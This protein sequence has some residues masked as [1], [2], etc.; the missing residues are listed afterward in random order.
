MNDD[1]GDTSAGTDSW[2]CDNSYLVLD[3]EQKCLRQLPLGA[4]CRPGLFLA[5]TLAVLPEIKAGRDDKQKIAGSEKAEADF[6]FLS[7]FFSFFFL[8]LKSSSLICSFPARGEEDD[9]ISRRRRSTP[10]A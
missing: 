6:V 2:Q 3:R 10:N 7:I 1:T 8:P 4:R 9:L 5:A